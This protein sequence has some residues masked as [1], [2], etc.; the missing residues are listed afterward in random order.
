MNI[1][2]KVVD[3]FKKL[4]IGQWLFLTPSVLWFVVLLP[5]ALKTENVSSKSPDGPNVFTGILV[6]WAICATIG[7]GLWCGVKQQV[8]ISR[9]AKE[10]RIRAEQD[11]VFALEARQVHLARP[12]KAIDH[13]LTTLRNFD[14]LQEYVARAVPN[15]LG[16]EAVSLAIDAER[17]KLLLLEFHRPTDRVINRTFGSRD[18]LEVSVEEQGYSQSET[19]ILTSTRTQTTTSTGSMMGRALVGGVLLGPAGALAG[20]VTARRTGTS[21]TLGTQ[22]TTHI[23]VVTAVIL[24]V[25]VNDMQRPIFIINFLDDEVAK[26]TDDYRDAVE[27]ASRWHGVL[28]VLQAAGR[29]AQVTS[30]TALPSS[31]GLDDLEKLASLRDKGAITDAEFQAKKKQILGL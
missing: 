14:V 9:R 1:L 4:T 21:N 30:P 10:G 5:M 13:E 28:S 22:S 7:V 3:R 18:I 8:A 26:N 17:Q 31:L 15:N 2:A 6:M 19:T 25:L 11:R 27:Q 24:K 16:V 29:T 23:D 12:W 20:G